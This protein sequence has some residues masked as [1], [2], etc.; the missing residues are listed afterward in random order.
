MS[1]AEA[2]SLFDLPSATSQ[3][4][5]LAWGQIVT[6]IPQHAV[7]DRRIDERLPARDRSHRG[8]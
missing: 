6:R 2:T 3:H 1:S 7:A 8:E 4:V 5:E